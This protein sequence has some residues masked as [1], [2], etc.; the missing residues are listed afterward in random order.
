MPPGGGGGG[1]QAPPNQTSTE[2]HMAPIWV[3]LG[4]F[5]FGYVLWV[6]ARGPIVTAFCYFKLAEIQFLSLF[7]HHLV[8]LKPAIHEMLK[9][10]KEVGYEQLA[11]LAKSV[12][13]VMMI[14]VLVILSVLSV[15][16]YIRSSTAQYRRTYTMDS[17][18]KLESPLWPQVT[19][20]LGKDL[21]DQHIEKGGW[22]MALTPMQFAK[23]NKLLKEN[24]FVEDENKRLRKEKKV[25][26]SVIKD[27]AMQVFAEQ[28]GPM[29]RGTR[30]LN[31]HTRALFAAFA[32][33][34]CNDYD[35]SHKLLMQIAASSN[36]KLNFSGTNELLKKYE[37]HKLIKTAVKEHAYVLTVMAS[38]IV[39]ARTNGVLASAD[40]LWLK[41]I[42]RRL[43]FL[44]NTIGRQTAPAEVAGPFAHW[45][46]EKELGRPIKTPMVYQAV[47]ALEEAVEEIV[48]QPDEKKEE[49][50]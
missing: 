15:L 8:T 40:F 23:K 42:D 17:L 28:L 30:S 43:W 11:L 35:A 12:G 48:Y 22:S 19:P 3:L 27:S 46:A 6:M 49:G 7:D 21:V 16:L 20:V 26:V 33:R 32:A 38:M 24:E 9:N 4:V 14:P 36:G 2:N 47:P 44:L 50:D 39:L 1:G 45:L 41:P 31:I 25:T 13:R 37:N 34:A 29:W 5:I 18:L 10:P